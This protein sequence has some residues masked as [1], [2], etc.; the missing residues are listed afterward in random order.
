MET[1]CG[2]KKTGKDASAEDRLKARVSYVHMLNLTFCVTRR[3]ICA[4]LED[5]QT[6][7]GVKVPEVLV[8]FMGGI[9]LLKFERRLIEA[10]RREKGSKKVGE[11]G[12][13]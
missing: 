4:I 2:M 7:E 5:H 10:T 3:G 6:E 13:E 12:K 11:G 8:P 1:S 9:D